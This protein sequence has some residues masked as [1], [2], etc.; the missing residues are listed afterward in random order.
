MSDATIDMIVAE[1]QRRY[2]EAITRSHPLFVVDPIRYALLQVKY[3]G[4][5]NAKDKAGSEATLT[6]NRALMHQLKNTRTL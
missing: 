1:I 4:I 2:A 6:K 3:G 5:R